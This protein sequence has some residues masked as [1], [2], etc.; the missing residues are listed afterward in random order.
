MMG[1]WG[2]LG[3]TVPNV[4]PNFVGAADSLTFLTSLCLPVSSFPLSS[5]SLMFIVLENNKKHKKTRNKKQISKEPE[6]AES[7]HTYLEPKILK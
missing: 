1:V 7:A 6:H 4:S 5:P 3:R 2:F